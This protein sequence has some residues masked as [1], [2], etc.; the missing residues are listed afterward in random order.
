MPLSSSSPPLRER[1]KQRRTD[2]ILESARELLRE[3]PD[4]PLTVERIA[5]RA[6]VSQGTVFNLVGTRDRIWAALADS[7]IGVLDLDAM[8]SVG[9]PLERAHAIVDALIE[10]VLTDPA[11]FR[12][13]FAHW[14]ES[15]RTIHA[16]PTDALLRTLQA[17]VNDGTLSADAP[18]PRIADAVA[19]GLIGVLHQWA[20]GLIGGKALRNRGRD[21][22][23]FA[24]AAAAR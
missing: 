20:A 9:S 17:G 24:F 11:V 2:R 10:E 6:E 23:E 3:Q 13:V 16:N 22:F 7:A 18:L 1:N 15:A 8:G 19:S 12:A 21:L 5:E 14:A 4:R